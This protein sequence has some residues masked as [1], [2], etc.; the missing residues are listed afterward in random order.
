MEHPIRN[1]LYPSRPHLLDIFSFILIVVETCPYHNVRELLDLLWT[2]TPTV[3]RVVAPLDA[4]IECCVTEGGG[5]GC[6]TVK[7]EVEMLDPGQGLISREVRFYAKN[8]SDMGAGYGSRIRDVVEF[9][10]VE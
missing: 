6:P 7:V 9:G 4:E 10:D 5:F 1:Y 8:E 3:L 2:K